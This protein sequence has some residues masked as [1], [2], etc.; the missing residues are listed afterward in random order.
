[1]GLFDGFED[2]LGEVSDALSDFGATDAADD[3]DEATRWIQ[4]RIDQAGSIP[5][6]RARFLIGDWPANTVPVD[7]VDWS[8]AIVQAGGLGEKLLQQA[9]A[10]A[11][12]GELGAAALEQ[13]LD[14]RFDL[15]KDHE[16]PLHWVERA[17]ITEGLNQVWEATVTLAKPDVAGLAAAQLGLSQT[18]LSLVDTVD[19]AFSDDDGD[20]WL[21]LSDLVTLW[22]TGQSAA[23][24]P[25]QLADQVWDVQHPDKLDPTR[26][27]RDHT[28]LTGTPFVGKTLA[29]DYLGA[30]ARLGLARRFDTDHFTLNERW[31]SGRVVAF[32]DLG[33]DPAQ[34]LRRMRV[35]IRPHL[36]QLSLRRRFRAFHEMNAVQIVRRI[37][38]EHGIY[39]QESDKEVTGTAVRFVPGGRELF[40]PLGVPDAATAAIGKLSGLDPFGIGDTVSDEVNSVLEQPIEDWRPRREQCVQ[41]GETDLEFMQRLLEEEGLTFF[42]E[43]RERLETLVIC[44]DPRLAGKKVLT[45]GRLPLLG[46]T[47]NAGPMAAPSETAWNVAVARK[48]VSSGVTLRDRIYTRPYEPAAPVSSPASPSAWFAICSSPPSVVSDDRFVGLSSSRDSPAFRSVGS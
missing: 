16:Q 33:Y 23:T 21:E 17:E 42:F 32:E 46:A 30:F 37:L 25:D 12:F 20:G 3:L 10:A 4:S 36:H 2:P 31:F 43:H 38:E 8:D 47:S 1:M 5:T 22:N 7:Q 18:P 24:T 13:E 6:I 41:Y 40:G 45:A 48:P 14:K 9:G 26:A 34:R 27:T 28:E 44:E 19:R 29:K 11:G 35:T 15:E 39:Q